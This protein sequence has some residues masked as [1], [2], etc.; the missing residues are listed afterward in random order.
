MRRGSWLTVLLAAL[1]ILP[2]AVCMIFDGGGRSDPHHTV[3]TM[4]VDAAADHEHAASPLGA[5]QCAAHAAHCPSKSLPPGIVSLTL[6]ALILAA[7]TAVSTPVSTV[8]VS[9]GGLRGPPRPPS[10]Y[11]RA[12]LTLFGISRR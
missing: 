4:M 2:S 10:R 7:F 8:V 6:A 9:A 5:E 1:V 11:G 12:V 3:T